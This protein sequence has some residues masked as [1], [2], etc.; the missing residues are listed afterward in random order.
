MGTLISVVSILAALS[1]ASE[2]IVEMLKKAWDW[3][4]KEQPK[5]DE[6][7]R[8][9]AVHLIAAIIGTGLA[10]LSRTQIAAML[11]ADWA[12]HMGWQTYAMLGLMS[13]GGSAFWNTIL[14]ALRAIKIE[15]SAA[16]E[17]RVAEL[18]ERRKAMSL[19]ART[20]SALAA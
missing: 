6:S 19:P 2:R 3:L 12:S 11:P 9:A 10:W 17:L 5:T 4:G 15:K 7:L 8:Q 14:D 13:S 18:N 20:K 16:A 1:M